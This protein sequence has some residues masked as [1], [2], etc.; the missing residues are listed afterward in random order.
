MTEQE[1]E[2]EGASGGKRRDA[3]GALVAREVGVAAPLAMS[4]PPERS[5]EE[6]GPG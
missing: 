5:Y 2:K 3:A 4:A 1:E 6:R